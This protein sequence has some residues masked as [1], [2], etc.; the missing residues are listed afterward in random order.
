MNF[1]WAMDQAIHLEK[2]IRRMAWPRDVWLVLVVL[3][4]NPVRGQVHARLGMPVR[5]DIYHFP[6]QL[7][8]TD[9]GAQDWTSK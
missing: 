1:M 5:G 8:S 3:P 7:N 4:D 9:L 6:Y 2:S